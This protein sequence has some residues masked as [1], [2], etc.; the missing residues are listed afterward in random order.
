MKAASWVVKAALLACAVMPAGARAF[1]T[2]PAQTEARLVRARPA[3]KSVQ[4]GRLTALPLGLA[5]TEHMQ[6]AITPPVST[7]AG[8]LACAPR[9]SPSLSPARAPS[10]LSLP[11]VVPSSL[12]LCAREQ[13]QC[14]R[15]A[16]NMR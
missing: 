9:L 2:A 11:S 13:G 16:H 14:N 1:V 12:V 7:C 3:V 6:T 5:V 4:A 15:A 8:V 10:L